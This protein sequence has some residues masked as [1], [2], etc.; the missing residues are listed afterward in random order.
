MFLAPLGFQLWC[1][2]SSRCNILLGKVEGVSDGCWPALDLGICPNLDEEVVD[3]V[4]R[5]LPPMASHLRIGVDFAPN[6]YRGHLFARDCLH[7]QIRVADPFV[8]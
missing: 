3:F 7:E 1:D 6:G 5:G 8:P 4:V 2:A